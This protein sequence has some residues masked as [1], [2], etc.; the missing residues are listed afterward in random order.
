MKCARILL[1]LVA[2][3]APTIVSAQAVT[4]LTTGNQTFFFET[5]YASPGTPL[6]AITGLQGGETLIGIDTRP[7]NG[8]VYAVADSGR[9]YTVVGGVATFVSTMT[10]VPSGARFGIDF[11]P[12]VDRLRIVSDTGQN[13]RV[14]VDT[15]ATTVDG[16]INPAGPVIGGVAYINSFA[17]ATTTQLYY[18][19]SAGNQLM[20]TTLPNAGTV[21]AVGPLGVDFD[22]AAGFDIYP[23][24]GGNVAIA[25]LTVGGATNA[26]SINLTSG[27]A[28]LLGPAGTTPVAGIVAGASQPLLVPAG[29]SAMLAAMSLLLAAL[30][31]M[32]MR[33]RQVVFND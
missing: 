24:N 20:T 28:T 18:L 6:Q 17:G 27:A 3:A 13:L 19:D 12:T 26:Y 11:N 31:W 29:G 30:A 21:T 16:T 32:A 7:A 8:R 9:I 33:R 4:A 25:V 14:N 23:T 2:F 22:S 1:A 10:T 15:G 5:S